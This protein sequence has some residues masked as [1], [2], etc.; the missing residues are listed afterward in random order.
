M[1]TTYQPPATGAHPFAATV[2]AVLVLHESAAYILDAIRSIDKGRTLCNCST[3]APKET[4]FVCG[5]EQSRSLL[6]D[7]WSTDNNFANTFLSARTF[8]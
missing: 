4:C 7:Y 3:A 2:R 1:H 6:I 8:D 5:S